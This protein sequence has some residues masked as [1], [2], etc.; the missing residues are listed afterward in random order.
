MNNNVIVRMIEPEDKIGAIVIASVAKEK[1]TLAEVMIPPQFSYHINGDLK[2]SILKVGM[3]VRIPAGNI[4][5]GIPEAPQGE[6][7]LCLAEDS[8]YYVTEEI[9]ND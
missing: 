6:S 5:T 2:D 4:G 3:K 9:K 1:S 8:I 7:W